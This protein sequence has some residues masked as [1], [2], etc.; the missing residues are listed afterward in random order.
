[1]CCVLEYE[2]EYLGVVITIVAQLFKRYYPVTVETNAVQCP[3]AIVH[4][5]I[6]LSLSI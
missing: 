5:G 2:Y 3:I 4:S 6:Y 1:M